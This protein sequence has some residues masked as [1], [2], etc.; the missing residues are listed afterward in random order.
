MNSYMSIFPLRSGVLL[1]DLSRF[2]EVSTATVSQQSKTRE[3]NCHVEEWF[4]IVK[5]RILQTKKFLRPADFIHK[6][7]GS[8]QGRFREHIINNSL[9]LPC[10]DPQPKQNFFS[11]KEDWAAKK[12]TSRKHKKRR[13]KYFDPPFVLTQPSSPDSK[14]INSNTSQME[15]TILIPDK[16]MDLSTTSKHEPK[17]ITEPH[18]TEE[19]SEDIAD[20][21]EYLWSKKDCELVVAVVSSAEKMSRYTVRHSE[22]KT[23]QPHKWLVGE[24]RISMRYYYLKLV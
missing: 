6:M 12:K 15:T 17:Y 2:S 3:T 14:G 5:H 13:T 4:W 22:F 21:I 18:K 7:Y 11:Q 10:R 16:P 9:I 24:A 1:G 23:L 8:P 20:E 19:T